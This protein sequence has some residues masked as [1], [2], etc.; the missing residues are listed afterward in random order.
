[1]A[2][3]LCSSVRLRTWPTRT[4]AGAEHTRKKAGGEDNRD[5]DVYPVTHVHA[6]LEK[7]RVRR[8]AACT[9]VHLLVEGILK[10]RE[11]CFELDQPRP[12]TCNLANRPIVVNAFISFLVTCSICRFGYGRRHVR[13][14]GGSSSRRRSKVRWYL[15]A[16]G[17]EFVHTPALGNTNLDAVGNS[18]H[19]RDFVKRNHT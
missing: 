7:E 10:P 6:D 14:R 12:V 4:G 1:M 19:R 9:H 11:V 8:R 3:F 5:R 13:L 17:S 16:L 18:L 2:G 15:H